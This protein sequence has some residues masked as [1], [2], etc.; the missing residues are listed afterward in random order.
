MGEGA[1]I[2]ILEVHATMLEV[3]ILSVS[4]LD[5]EKRFCHNIFKFFSGI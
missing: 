4:T 5:P 3:P 1:G 2:M